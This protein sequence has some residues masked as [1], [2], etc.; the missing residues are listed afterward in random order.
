MPEVPEEPASAAAP[1]IGQPKAAAPA[2]KDNK[3]YIV[4][5]PWTYDLIQGN[6]EF[7]DI[8][9]QGVGMSEDELER[10]QKA[11]ST[12]YLRLSVEEAK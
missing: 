12:L 8:T 9:P 7:P 4:S 2:N 1:P 5:S 10:A 11:C 3:R 6:G